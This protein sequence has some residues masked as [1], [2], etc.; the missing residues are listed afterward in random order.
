MGGLV[1]ETNAQVGDAPH[2]VPMIMLFP[3]ITYLTPYNCE[4]GNNDLFW[5]PIDVK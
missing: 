2:K 4:N 3:T 5:E 1:T